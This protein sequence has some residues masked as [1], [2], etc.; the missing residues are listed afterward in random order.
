MAQELA[1]RRPDISLLVTQGRSADD[2]LSMPELGLE[3]L[4]RARLRADGT[5]ELVGSGELGGRNLVMLPY[6]PDPQDFY[7]R[8][9]GVTK[10]LLMP[11]LWEESFGLVAAE[12]MLNGIPVL[13]SNRGA[14]PDTVGQGG[15]IF[16]IPTCYTPDTRIVATV[17]EIE[18][19]LQTIIHLWDD[20]G[21]YARASESARTEAQ[22]WHPDR[23]LPFY[24]DFFSH[25]TTQ[26]SPPIAPKQTTTR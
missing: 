21:F 13:A 23:L 17:E 4:V 18:P 12:A 9:F 7:P 8:V 25:L 6:L 26:P 15:F 16:N 11:S 10:I 19:W 5:E 14:L 22:R 1:R 20:A 2:A 3:P 24:R